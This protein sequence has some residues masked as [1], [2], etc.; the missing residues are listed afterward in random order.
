MTQITIGHVTRNTATVPGAKSIG[1]V[2]PIQNSDVLV[3]D[4][5]GLAAA[6]G[7][8]EVGMSVT[9]PGVGT[10]LQRVRKLNGHLQEWIS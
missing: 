3:V 10:G 8:R 9:L 5:G 1:D 7:L 4:G 6:R 2:A